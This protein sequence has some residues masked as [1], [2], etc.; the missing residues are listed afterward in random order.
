M[1]APTSVLLVCYLAITFSFTII[2]VDC[3]QY[4]KGCQGVILYCKC[5]IADLRRMLI[6]AK[7]T[8]NKSDWEPVHGNDIE[9]TCPGDWVLM[10]KVV[11][12]ED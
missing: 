1:I 11:I 2:I 8:H 4:I 3:I 12:K 5:I 9:S 7:Q 10:W 6:H